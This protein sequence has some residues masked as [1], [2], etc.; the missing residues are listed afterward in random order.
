MPGELPMRPNEA[1]ALADLIFQHLDGR[2]LTDE[3]RSRLAARV[4][5]LEMASLR[6]R[7]VSLVRDPVHRSSY[8]M[9]V[10]GLSGPAPV[11]LLLHMA[12]ASAPASALFPKALLVGRMRP[13]GGREIVVN[14]VPFGIGDTVNIRVFAEKLDRAFLPRPQGAQPAI[15]VATRRPETDLPAA[16]DAFRQIWKTTSVNW[17]SFTAPY[18]AVLWAAIRAGWREG[19]NAGGDPLVLG[20]A[21]GLIEAKESIRQ[22]TGFTRFTIDASHVSE[23]QPVEEL[24]DC[25]RTAKA[26]SGLGRGFDFEFSLEKTEKPTTADDLNSY[27][28]RLKTRGRAAQLVSP[29]VNPDTVT[30]LAAVTRQFNATLSISSDRVFDDSALE[31]FV[32]ATAGRLNYRITAESGIDPARLVDLASRLR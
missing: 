12:L 3:A 29:N 13:A 26:A 4:A 20:G 16:F 15:A 27:L 11:P 30:E 31:A 7:I 9:P 32:K 21:T 1:A 6:P 24:Y 28:Q 22:S 25:I 17:A 14:A 5:G 8:Y 19:Y 23:V 2:P 10:D 18:E